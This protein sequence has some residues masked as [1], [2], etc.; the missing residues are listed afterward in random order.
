MENRNLLPVLPTKTLKRQSP[1]FEAEGKQKNEMK[2]IFRCPILK[3]SAKV[4]FGLC[5]SAAGKL[6][7]TT[8]FI[9]DR[10][11]CNGARKFTCHDTSCM[12]LRAK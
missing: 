2:V 9:L 3:E 4:E 5:D 11:Q 10:K 7:N 6:F 8:C 1:F 12:S